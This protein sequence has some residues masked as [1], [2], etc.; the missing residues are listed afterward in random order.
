MVVA[1]RLDSRAAGMRVDGCDLAC[2][3]TIGLT[4]LSVSFIGFRLTTVPD[5]GP[6]AP[7]AIWNEAASI[8]TSPDQ[9]A[10]I[11]YRRNSASAGSAKARRIRNFRRPNERR[12]DLPSA[13]RPATTASSAHP[14]S[15][16]CSILQRYQTWLSCIG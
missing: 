14:A 15:K 3:L 9:N 10:A 4:L 7:P 2:G 16:T 11:L 5:L 6:I 8:L 1:R 13:A 12:L